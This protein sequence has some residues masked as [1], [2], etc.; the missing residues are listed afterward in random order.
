MWASWV[1][2]VGLLGEKREFQHQLEGVVDTVK[3]PIL[4]LSNFLEE[5]ATKELP[6]AAISSEGSTGEGS[7]SKFIYLVVVRIQILLGY[8][9][10]DPVSLAV[11]CWLTSAPCHGSCLRGSSQHGSWHHRSEYARVRERVSKMDS[12]VK[13]EPTVFL[14]PDFKSNNHSLLAY[15]I[16]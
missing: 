12:A 2:S 10:E 4:H 1:E 7:T 14:L 8:W 13:V 3:Q 6:G 16:F 11:G 5:A 9:T 15:F